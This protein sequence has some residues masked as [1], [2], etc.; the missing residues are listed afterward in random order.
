MAQSGGGVMDPILLAMLKNHESTFMAHGVSNAGFRNGIYRGKSLGT[1][2]TPEQWTAIE[3]GTF[4]DMYIGDYWTINGVQYII[5]AFNYYY[6]TG[7]TALTQNHVTLVPGGVLYTHAMNDSDTTDGGYVGSRMYD[8]GL[9]QAKSIIDAAF[10]GRVLTHRKY[11]SNATSSGHASAAVWLD[12]NVELMNEVMV[13]GSVVNGTVASDGVFNIGVEKSQLPL[14]ALRPD[15][16]GIRV[17]WWLRDV[18]SASSFAYVPSAG[19][20]TRAT[21]SLV[22]GVRPAFSIS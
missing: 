10:P 18:T 3:A 11:L 8:E 9:S 5:A 22:Y 14:F 20:A 4:D 16:I 19:T 17:G 1:S 7:D 15:L 12:S 13:Y 2:V 21:A 6:N